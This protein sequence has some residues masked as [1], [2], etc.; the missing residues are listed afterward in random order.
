MLRR[1]GRLRRN[2]LRSFPV[3]EPSLSDFGKNQRGIRAAEAK[4]IGHGNVNLF[5]LCFEGYQ[6]HGSPDIWVFEIQSRRHNVL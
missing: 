1:D 4:A 2:M 3:D 6:I 5:R